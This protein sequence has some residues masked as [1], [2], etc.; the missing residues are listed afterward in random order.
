MD[1]HTCPQSMCQK[2]MHHTWFLVHSSEGSVEWEYSVLD[3]IL[4]LHEYLFLSCLTSTRRSL[5]NESKQSQLEEDN[6]VKNS[7]F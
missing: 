3:V 5:Y 6:L 2:V 1:L 4:C 7:S